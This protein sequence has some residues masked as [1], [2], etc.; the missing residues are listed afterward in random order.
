MR[1]QV[2]IVGAKIVCLPCIFAKFIEQDFAAIIPIDRIE[3]FCSF[4]ASDLESELL[5]SSRHF[6]FIDTTIIIYIDIVKDVP[7]HDIRKQEHTGAFVKGRFRWVYPLYEGG[8][9]GKQNG[10]NTYLEQSETNI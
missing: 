2:A 7:L 10:Q 5:Q 8:V 9:D 6:G 4:L 1:L 3:N